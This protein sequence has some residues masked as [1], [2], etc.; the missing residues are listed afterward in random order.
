MRIL[1]ADDNQFVG[2]VIA[3]ILAQQ[4]GWVLCGEASTSQE[5]IER[6]SELHPDLVLLDV[7]YAR[8]KWLG[9]YASF[10]TEI[11]ADSD[12]DYYSA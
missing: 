5:A 1:L 8:R 12:P 7:D 2:R 6:T 3:G 4:E 10:E 9:D 11:P